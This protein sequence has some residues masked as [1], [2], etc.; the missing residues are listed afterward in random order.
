MPESEGFFQILTYS[1]FRQANAVYGFF[2]HKL[3]AGKITVNQKIYIL[4]VH[5]EM[6]PEITYSAVAKYP[7][8]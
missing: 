8:F 5:L 2:L 6:C 4:K 3:Y 1:N 7:D